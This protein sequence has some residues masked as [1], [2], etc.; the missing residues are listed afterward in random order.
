AC[1]LS[2][3]LT[4]SHLNHHVPSLPLRLHGRGGKGGMTDRLH[5]KN[6]KST[7]RYAWGDHILAFSTG[8]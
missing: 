7:S 5:I 1:A 2:V 4:L 8:R 3:P 6:S